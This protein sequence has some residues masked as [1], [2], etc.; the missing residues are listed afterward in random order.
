MVLIVN[1]TFSLALLLQ[2]DMDPARLHINNMHP[3]F[4]LAEKYPTFLLAEKYYLSNFV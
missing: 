3:T 2:V 4:L 1:V